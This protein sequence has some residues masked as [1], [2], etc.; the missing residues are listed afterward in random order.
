MKFYDYSEIK[1]HGNGIEIANA[2]NL[3]PN[4]DNRCKAIWRNGSNESSVLLS[5][6]GFHDFGTESGGSIIDLVALAKFGAVNDFNL[7]QAQNWLGN[8]L[9]LTPKSELMEVDLTYRYKQFNDEGFQEVKR[10]DYCDERGCVLQVIRLENTEGKKRFL[11][12]DPKKMAWSVKN[13]IPPLYNQLN[14]IN[15]GQVIVVEGEKDAD[16]LIELK[17]PATTCAGGARKW[18]PEYTKTLKGK[19]VYILPDNDPA[20][21]AHAIQIA[22][23]I[24]SSVAEVKI[25][26]CSTKAKGDVSDFLDNG[27][28]ID[29]LYTLIN[30]AEPITNPHDLAIAEVLANAKKAN[31]YDFRNYTIIKEQLESGAVKFK[32]EPRHVLDMIRDCQ[33]R[34]LGFPR[35]VGGQ[36]FDHD[37]DTG[38]IVTF[39]NPTSIATWMSCKSNRNV[40]FVRG[41]RNVTKE[42]FFEAL[43]QN[44][45]EY[46]TISY[47]PTWPSRDSVYYAVPPMPAADPDHKYFEKFIDFFKPASP[48]DR[49]LLKTFAAAPL[50]FKEGLPRPMWV[51]DSEHGQGTGKTTIAEVVASL[52][53][54]IISCNQRELRDGISNIK[55]RI[56]TSDGRRSKI[57]LIDNVTGKLASEELSS[58]ITASTIT[59]RVPYGREET[60]R[61]NDLTYVVTANSATFDTDLASRAFFIF[62]KR[63]SLSTFWKSSLTEFIE[64]YRLNILA[65]ILDI[66]QTHEPFEDI[67]PS[68]RF[69]EFEVSI[70]QAM[71]DDFEQYDEVIK[72]IFYARSESNAD[73]D[74]A[75]QFEDEVRGRLIDFNIRPDDESVFIRSEVLQFWSRQL[76]QKMSAPNIINLAKAG[77]ISYINP[78]IIRYP[79]RG[80]EQRRGVMW[81]PPTVEQSAMK[82]IG[83]REQKPTIMML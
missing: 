74:L 67:N 23:S 32:K 59:G 12:Y 76:D 83:L 27:G 25:V 36:L 16:R 81:Q 37:R 40:E 46:D 39:N 8:H 49:I 33:E 3:N 11:Q 63:G 45:H 24:F 66:I 44:S 29:S 58:I 50:Y 73:E 65:D 53:G 18:R 7:Q 42:M 71:C 68:T 1:A 64:K 55:Q 9:S 47:V 17:L 75:R 35:K 79:H 43:L 78:R 26:K 14:I 4:K 10:Y 28:T 82:I 57:F 20:G 34:F 2:L 30:K 19:S 38:K 21:E 70:M 5:S 69:P 15:S 52:Y 80:P 22:K 72:K 13:I 61:P 56:L 48:E 77:L 51:I 6:D 62:V 54:P 31:S 41:D 60:R